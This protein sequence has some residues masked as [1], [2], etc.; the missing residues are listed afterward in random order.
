M[1]DRLEQER[2]VFARLMETVEPF[3]SK[4]I[5]WSFRQG[6][7]HNHIVDGEP[8]SD[9]V[10]FSDSIVYDKMYLYLGKYVAFIAVVRLREMTR[11]G[12]EIWAR[13]LFSIPLLRDPS[14]RPG[15]A[16]QKCLERFNR[17]LAQL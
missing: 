12:D 5:W 14:I 3:M 15:L 8:R 7:Y 4:V 13:P 2:E 11:F 17:S 6:L 16:A 10:H 1:S 9:L